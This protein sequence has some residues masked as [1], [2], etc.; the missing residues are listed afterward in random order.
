MR[1]LVLFLLLSS[2]CVAEDVFTTFPEARI[3]AMNEKRPMMIIISRDACPFC[4]MLENVVKKMKRDGQLDKPVVVKLNVSDGNKYANY[5]PARSYPTT[6]FY[7]EDS[8][9][10]FEFKGYVVREQVAAHVKRYLGE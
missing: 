7:G 5:F 3:V 4:D 8:K 1:T 10:K 9:L 2:V 6:Y